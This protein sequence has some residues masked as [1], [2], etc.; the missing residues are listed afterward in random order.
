MHRVYAGRFVSGIVQFS[1]INGSGLWLRFSYN[2]LVKSLRAASQ[3]QSGFAH[4]VSDWA[5]A[6][7]VVATLP[8]V[9]LIAFGIWVITDAVRL[10]NGNFKDGRGNKITRWI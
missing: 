1:L 8:V 5:Q 10:R 2:D 9:A 4:A 6:G 3:E 7:G